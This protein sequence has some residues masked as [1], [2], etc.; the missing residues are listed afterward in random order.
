MKLFEDKYFQI[1]STDMK[2]DKSK[3]YELIEY[4]HQI[5]QKKSWAGFQDP[6]LIL[7]LFLKKYYGNCEDCK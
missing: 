2:V 1:Y 5:N 3:Q 7:F 6:A 4:N